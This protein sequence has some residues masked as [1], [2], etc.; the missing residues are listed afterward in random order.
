MELFTKFNRK[1]IDDRQIDTLIGI[2][3]GLIADGKIDQVEA[4]FLLTWLVQS[5]QA[6]RSRFRRRPVCF[7]WTELRDRGCTHGLR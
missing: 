6:P 4:E 1:N 7:R 5:R 2:G 3:K